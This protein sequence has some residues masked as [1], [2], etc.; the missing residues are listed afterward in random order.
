LYLV[1]TNVVSEARR[2]SRQAVGWLRSVRPDAVHLSALTLGEIM[3][4]IVL[5]QK[6]DPQTAARLAEWLERLRHD[7]TDRILPVTD[8]IALEWGRIAALRPRGDVDGLIAA[9]AIVHDLILVTR[10][11][12][13]FEDTRV[14]LINP[15]DIG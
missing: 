15:W 11:V 9:T 1:D 10:N 2:G 3:R 7:H 5:R 8:R 12:G 6:S 4:G 13:D 14:S